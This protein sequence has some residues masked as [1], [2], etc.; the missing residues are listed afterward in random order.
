MNNPVSYF[1]DLPRHF[2]DFYATAAICVD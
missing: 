1:V 2:P